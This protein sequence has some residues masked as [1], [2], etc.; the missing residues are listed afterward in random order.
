VEKTPGRPPLKSVR[1]ALSTLVVFWLFV[2]FIALLFTSG[3]GLLLLPGG[4]LGYIVPFWAP[5]AD[6]GPA[7]AIL[8]IL[9]QLALHAGFVMTGEWKYLTRIAVLTLLSLG[10]TIVLLRS[11]YF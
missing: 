11:P 8:W 3:W 4:L 9:A 1:E 10:G 6:L 7:I 2:G 5:A